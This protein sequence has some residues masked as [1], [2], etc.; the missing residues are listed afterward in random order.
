MSLGE[1]LKDFYRHAAAFVDKI[2]KGA[3]PGDLPIEQLSLFDL[4]INRKTAQ[5]LGLTLPPRSDVAA[6]EVID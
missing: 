2:F 6:Y 5:T 4:A 1:S 3:R